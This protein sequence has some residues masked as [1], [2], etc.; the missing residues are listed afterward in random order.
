MKKIIP[1]LQV[2]M[3]SGLINAQVPVGLVGHFP[4]S[5]G[6]F[7]DLAGYQDCILSTNGDSIYYL[8]E[9][10]FENSN[11]AI[12]FQGAVLNGGIIS[13]DI[14]NEIT[15]SLWMK[16][17]VL[18]EETKFVIN[19]YYCVEPPQ[20]YHMAVHGDSITFDGRDNT[21]NGYMRSGWSETT[22][23]DGE[24]HH[25]VGLARSEG[26]WELWVDAQMESSN[27]YSPIS[28]L[29]HT[30]CNLGIAGPDH[31]NETRI[32]KGALD[33]IRI[34]NRALDSLEIDSLFNEP[35]PITTSLTENIKRSLNLNIY[36][37]P[38][39]DFINLKRLG[40]DKIKQVDIYNASGI[41][42]CSYNFV[43]KKIKIDYLPNGMYFLKIS[44]A[45]GMIGTQKFVVKK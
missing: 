43:S 9:D 1:V 21:S 34:Y 10:R 18:A 8:T 37:S 27:V 45:T 40:K 20:G 12:D 15:V 39:S 22:V 14:T 35:N 13:R 44:T 41:K 32:Y 29:N 23:N 26:I 28:S 16:T 19:K 4:F 5:N 7:E 3:I 30:F 25:V 31:N 33:D 6:S 17:T 36:P 11:Y 38:A 24:W 42:V 2:L